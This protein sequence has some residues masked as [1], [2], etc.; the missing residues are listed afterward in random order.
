MRVSYK[1]Y[2]LILLAMDSSVKEILYIHVY[3][4]NPINGIAYYRISDLKFPPCIF[5]LLKYKPFSI[6]YSL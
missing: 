5:W 4:G 2:E 6:L 3:N 1:F